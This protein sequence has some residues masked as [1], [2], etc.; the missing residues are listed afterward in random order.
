VAL[1]RFASSAS[2]SL[3]HRFSSIITPSASWSLHQ[4]RFKKKRFGFFSNHEDHTCSFIIIR[5]AVQVGRF[6][7]V[8]LLMF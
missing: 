1:L 8:G 5:S 3:N 7:G 4:L 2:S 6:L